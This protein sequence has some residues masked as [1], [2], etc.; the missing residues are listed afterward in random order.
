MNTPI[1]ALQPQ[2]EIEI[3]GSMT[4]T[5]YIM[6]HY[7]DEQQELLILNPFTTLLVNER[8]IKVRYGDPG[9]NDTKW[10][11]LIIKNI[12]ED[13]ENK[14][15]TITAKS[16]F[17]N[18][19]S[20]SGFNLVFDTEL[21][22]NMGT[23]EELA[24][25]VLKETDWK[26]KS[27]GQ[28]LEQKIEE[29]LYEIILNRE[30]TGIDM[31]DPQ[32]TIQILPG[33]K[34]YA[35]YT[36]IVNQE[37]YLQFLYSENYEI[38]DDSVIVNSNNW[39]IDQITYNSENIPDIAASMTIST[40]YRGERLVR[41]AKTK[42]D[43]TIDKYVNIYTNGDDEI[44]GYTETQYLSPASVKNY[45]TNGSNFN[46]YLG[47]D[48]GG[49]LIDGQL[50]FP[51]FSLVSIP[52]VRDVPYQQIISGE[53]NFESSLKFSPKSLQQC[54]YNS[55]IIDYRQYINGFIEGE[56]YVF[57]ARYGK[58][59]NNGNNGPS[60]LIDT[61]SDLKF[62]ICKYNLSNG[63][64]TFKDIYFEGI[65]DSIASNSSPDYKYIIT[66]CKKSLPYSEMVEM[67]NNL[68]LFIIPMQLDTYFI[69]DIEF[70][71][72]VDNS[73]IPLLP[74]EIQDGQVKTIY[75]YY[76]PN[77]DYKSIE[78]VN[79]IYKGD[80]PANFEEVYNDNSYEKVRSI[81]ES[82]SNRFNILQS[83]C[84]TF[85][86]WIDFDIEHNMETG[87]ILLDENYRQ[88]K[89]VSFNE[90]IGKDNFA[91]FKYGINLQSIKRTIQSEDIATKLIVKN[92]SNE[93]G[94]DGFC[95]IARSEYNNSGENFILN[96]N[97]YIQQGL[98][99]LSE[100]TN[101]LYMDTNGYIGYYKK[102]KQINK[103]RDKYIKEQSGLLTD[104]SEYQALYQTYS[105][106]VSESEKQLKDNYTNIKNLTGYTFEQLMEDK[107]NDWW[108][109]E[110]LLTLIASIGR[111]QSIIKN[112]ISLSQNAETN[113]NKAQN[114]YDE[115]NDILTSR[116][117]S[118]NPEDERLLLEKEEL[119]LKFY[120]KY[121]R[122]LQE[123]SWISEDYVDDNLYYLDAEN[124]SS[125]S[126]M[127]EI[128]YEIN[129]LELSQI[130]E[131]SNYIF[132]IGDRT[133]IEDTDYFGWTYKDGVRT[134][135]KEE[136]VLT[137]ITI[138]FDQPE[139][140]KIQV[141][142]YKSQFEDLFQ[143]MN[144]TTQSVQFSTG[145]YN[146]V[147]SI[148][149]EDGTINIVTLQ[150]SILNN[151]LT[152]E[153]AKDQSVIWDETGIT[154][155]SPTSPSEI[156]RIIS[157]GIFL[158]IDGGI[159][160]NTGITGKGINASYITSGSINTEEINILNGA[161]PSFR[162]DNLGI[163]A[164]QF[165]INQ[166]TNIISNFNYGKFVRLDQYGIYGINGY[167]NFDS[168]SPDEQ[169]IYGEDKIWKYSNFALT[170]KGFQIKSSHIDGGYISITSDND[171]QVINSKNKPQV[172][173]G[174]LN[175]SIDDPIYGIQLLDDE[176]NTVLEQS[177][178]GKVW[179][180]NEIKIGGS[181]STV[182]IGYLSNIKNENVHEVI[183][184]NNKFIVYEDGSMTATEANITGIIN[185]IGGQIGNLTIQEIS[186]IG[187]QVSVESED[188]NT[189][190]NNEG[191][192]I[193][194]ARLYKGS[195][196]ITSNLTYQ[197]YRNSVIL[198]G[199]NSKTLEVDASDI[200]GTGS[201]VYMCN[202]NTID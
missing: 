161:F 70:F 87:E 66:E 202:I 104:I 38:N 185:A 136:I 158:S 144:A 134:P 156:V 48:V 166:E 63:I 194:T 175:N 131:Y 82:E 154:T 141:Q 184:A 157:G 36:N 42:Y 95:S 61:D 159:T 78:D 27:N 111:L 162:W 160:W 109:S 41:K 121:S 67:T 195:E 88:K 169:G 83:L 152:L 133:Y 64:Y 69:L 196:E 35:F 102:L 170:W 193:L 37:S 58:P 180:K 93:F 11:D 54:L 122:F 16:L 126:A 1:R 191:T 14:T 59:Y 24:D 40:I 10:Y 182:S 91:G 72:Y 60:D 30:I 26:I 85:E 119:N 151:S 142:N 197:W 62:I 130:E 5:F 179:I 192:K 6:S 96:F 77:E 146:K 116:E 3:N 140:N 45:V 167:P 186:S 47:W 9:K 12:E 56:K 52:D 68:G 112:N 188:G 165:Q 76:I 34:I 171:L 138:A 168:N 176:G 43:S 31:R 148:V 2:F 53:I 139:Q 55:G 128:S 71:K 22:N 44:Y 150:N 33:S 32:N 198:T 118:E 98:L 117:Y 21:E 51:E 155:T 81:T 20:K 181:N 18:E 80:T 106:L 25:A 8:K 65:I 174:L 199:E 125:T 89:W 17:V 29:P 132:N 103:K 84:E 200:G 114:R 108:T 28:V 7:Y 172:K 105:L 73:G 113:L 100:I 153:N 124:I 13:S 120:K 164:Y 183:N 173:I 143:R 177:S 201:A 92:N 190:K 163:S 129:V 99:G 86:C 187:Y 115:L 178:Y 149:N 79:Y 90:Y 189:F 75:Y 145:K 4:L 49:A 50:Q 39:Y 94:T 107:E 74:N 123:G 15:I 101:D 147:S 110:Q 19:L 135:Y 57:R 137:K 127:P 97:Y 23:I 46:S